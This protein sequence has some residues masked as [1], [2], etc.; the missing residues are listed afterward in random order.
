MTEP[1]P[2]WEN[3]LGHDPGP[4]DSCDAGRH[5][6]TVREEKKVAKPHYCGKAP[7]LA[8]TVHLGVLLSHSSVTFLTRAAHSTRAAALTWIP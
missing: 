8:A 1:S 6:H 5:T 4:S 7:C 3:S 2:S